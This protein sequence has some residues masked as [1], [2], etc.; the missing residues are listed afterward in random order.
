MTLSPRLWREDREWLEGDLTHELSHEHLFSHLSPFEYYRIPVWFTEGIA[1]TASE[2]G[3]AQ[4]V[5]PLE[6]QRAICSGR[7]IET[8]DQ[9][10]LFGNVSLKAPSPAS[11]GDDIRLRMHM[12]YRQAGLFV[13]YLHDSNPIASNALLDRLYAGGQ[14]KEAFEAS[15][16]SSVAQDWL[17]FGERCSRT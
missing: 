3:G 4:R 8:P 16:K 14:F 10:N 7:T 12:A 15:Y 17:R 9:P 13:A 2:G 1:V 6:A 5:S 11:E